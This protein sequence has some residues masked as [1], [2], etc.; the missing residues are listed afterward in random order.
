MS[1]TR[2]RK[3]KT[4]KSRKN[5]KNTIKG[6]TTENKARIVGLFIEMLNVVKLYHWKTRS[7]AQHKATDHLYE[8][9]NENVDRFVEI[10]LGKDA[11]RVQQIEREFKRVDN[12]IDLKARIYEYRDSLVGLSQVLDG[13]RDSD[14]LNVRDELLGNLNQFLYLM[15]LSK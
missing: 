5:R 9:L 15:S 8:E 12:V 11:S 10:M 6:I 13:R 14:L 4:N 7:Y 2:T 3:P 1:K